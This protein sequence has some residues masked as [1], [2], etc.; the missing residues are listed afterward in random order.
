MKKTKKIRFLGL[1]ASSCAAALLLVVLTKGEGRGYEY[2]P[3]SHSF[4]V[5]E[6]PVSVSD[7]EAAGAL[8]EA[9]IQGVVS[10]STQFFLLS[11]WN[12]VEQVP[13]DMLDDRLLDSDPR[14]DGYA[15]KLRAFFVNEKTRRFFVPLSNWKNKN[16][17]V[18]EAAVR[19]A[20]SG[21][22]VSSII[23]HDPRSP[24]LSSLSRTFGMVGKAA[25]WAALFI[26][27][28]LFIPAFFK[29]FL[30]DRAY[31]LSGHHRNIR[32]GKTPV[33]V[34]L[35]L[36]AVF[37]A[38]GMAG[39][40]VSVSRFAL[41]VFPFAL[42]LL[43]WMAPVWFRWKAAGRRG[44]ILFHPVAMRETKP[45]SERGR[46]LVIIV[47]L[48]AI[49]AAACAASF[50][51]GSGSEDGQAGFS[52]EGYGGLVSE[53]EYRAHG[54]RQTVFAY[55]PLGVDR[56]EDAPPYRHYTEN[57]DGLYIAAETVEMEESVIPACPF[58]SLAAFIE[59]TGGGPDT[60]T[61]PHTTAGLPEALS[62]LALAVLLSSV[63]LGTRHGY[64]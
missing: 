6:C 43:G 33:A 40:V 2:L 52:N 3:P 12:G 37:I 31:R 36:T 49:G 14:R 20:L 58:D 18:I 51:I 46:P 27:C 13:L 60:I 25:V 30:S 54:R 28:G 53:E 32:R 34:S 63:I 41:I 22:P 62:F 29:N 15:Q 35:F 16:V 45:R 57:A 4:A 10:E 48:F 44:H 64:L 61:I 47:Y 8:G 38:S 50:F 7:R 5:V 56:E 21:L 11:A 1:Y 26:T 19:D 42:F 24:F 39:G 55:L 23:L 59:G 9:G 17:Q